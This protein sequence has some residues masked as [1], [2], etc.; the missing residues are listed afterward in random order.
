[1]EEIKPENT[2]KKM[3]LNLGLNPNYWHI[4]ES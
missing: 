1:M 4:L 3:S 2:D